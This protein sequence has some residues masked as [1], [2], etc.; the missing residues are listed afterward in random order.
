VATP[1]FNYYPPAPFQP[2]QVQAVIVPPPPPDPPVLQFGEATWVKDIKTTTHNPGKVGLRD[3]VDPDPDDP[4]ADDWT[5]GEPAEVE[6]EWRLLQTEFANPDNP[7]GVLEGVPQELPDGDEVVTRRYE[8]YKYIG[9]ID[10]ESGEAMADKVG[11]DGI[12]GAGTVTYNDHI[13]PATG[14]WV[15]VTVDLSTVEVVGEFFG[16]QMSGFDV[17]PALGLIDHVPDGELDV[18]YADR[19]VVVPG[20]AAFLATTS[21]SPYVENGRYGGQARPTV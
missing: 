8:F 1:T 2:A 9:P 13:D 18:A 14:E 6:T 10:G 21:G 17:A 12:H 20:A 16:A 19:A 15:K 5:N 3:L 11:P 4:S 7:K